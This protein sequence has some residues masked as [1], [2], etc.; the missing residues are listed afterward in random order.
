MTCGALLLLCAFSIGIWRVVRSGGGTALPGAA[1]VTLESDV[2]KSGQDLV[3]R[4]DGLSDNWS[5]ELTVNGVHNFVVDSR[6]FRLK[7][8]SRNGFETGQTAQ[9]YLLLIDSRG[10]QIPIPNGGRFRVQVVPPSVKIDREGRNLDAE[11]GSGAFEVTAA[12]MYNWSVTGVPEWIKIDAGQTGTGKGVV[13]YTVQENLSNDGRSAVLRI[14]DS[15]FTISQAHRSSVQVPFREKFRYLS[16]PPEFWTLLRRG[17]KTPDDSP[18]R[19]TWEQLGG[20]GGATLS[21]AHEKGVDGDS[22]VIQR[23]RADE[24]EWATLVYLPRLEFRSESEY[25]LTVWMKAEKP[26]DIV[27]SIS[28]NTEPWAGCGTKRFLRV[29]HEWAKYDV[30]LKVTGENCGPANNRLV[31]GVGHFQGKLWIADLSIGNAK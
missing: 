10:H 23:A 14:A 2:V 13:N 7:A 8:N 24:R 12:P 31:F 25:P 6:V 3:I 29:A 30:L 4:I 27:I 19:W 22:L 17:M 9:V 11:G 1:K 26:A 15:T 20:H 18:V 21:I 5:G 16:P 28:Q